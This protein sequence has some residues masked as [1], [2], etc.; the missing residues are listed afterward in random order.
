MSVLLWTQKQDVGPQQRVGAAAAYDATRGRVV[1]YGGTALP[2]G[3]FGDTWEWDGTD[4][5]QVADTG[6][7]ARSGHHLAF[8]S[9]R[10]RVVLFGGRGGDGA[11]R[12]DTWEWDGENWTQ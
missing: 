10:S 12:A 8:D 6:P 11:L 3:S 9:G 5:T 7:D 2:T 1:L 4:W